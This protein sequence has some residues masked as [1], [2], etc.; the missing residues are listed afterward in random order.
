M[1]KQL[2]TKVKTLSV[3]FTIDQIIS[4][5]RMIEVTPL[6]LS[7]NYFVGM[8][9]IREK[10]I[11]IIDM[12]EV[13]FNQKSEEK[14]STRLILVEGI[15]LQLALM[16]DEANEIIEVKD[17]D[18]Q[19]LPEMNDNPMFNGVFKSREKLVSMINLDGLIKGLSNIESIR[20]QVNQIN[21]I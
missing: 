5:E 17:E 2:I 4:I 10:V 9:R 21:I 8:G 13:L 11:P 18:I 20:E 15:G 1:E 7:S 6:P 12:N 16:V 14:D 3:S 19:P